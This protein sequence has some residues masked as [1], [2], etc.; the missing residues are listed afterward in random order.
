MKKAP[1]WRPKLVQLRCEDYMT[2]QRVEASHKLKVTQ[3]S[4]GWSLR[5]T[6]M[7]KEEYELET[8]VPSLEFNL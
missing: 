6:F 8:S 7:K 2:G 1:K 4:D 5:D 3:Y